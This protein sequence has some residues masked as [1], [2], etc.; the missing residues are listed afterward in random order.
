VPRFAI[1]EH[2]YPHRHWDLLLE[3]GAVL[4]GW[5]LPAPPAIGTTV[6]AEPTPPHR[7]LYLDYE[8]PI[9]GGRGQVAR[10]DA[11]ELEWLTNRDDAFA[12]RL[13]G[14]LL[15]AVLVGERQPGG[16]WRIT[17]EKLA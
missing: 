8:G 11:G 13:R 7:P 14:R 10:W 3:D 12:V 16:L 9:S 5:R 6:E 4:R 17:V 1:L 2:D 15:Q